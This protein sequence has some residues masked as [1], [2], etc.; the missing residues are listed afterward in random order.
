MCMFLFISSAGIYSQSQSAEQIK[1]K[2]AEIRRTTNWDNDSEAAKANA[3][4]KKLSKQLLVIAQKKETPQGAQTDEEIEK[5]AEHKQQMFDQIIKSAQAGEEADVLLADPIKEEIKEEFKEDES[6]KDF[7]EE[8][9]KE[10]TILVIDM[11]LKTIQRTISVMQNFKSIETL[12][13]TGGEKGATVNLNDLLTRAAAYPL[14]TLCIINFRNFVT[15]IP[16]QVNQFKNLKTLELFNNHLTK[17][18][19]ISGLASKLDS[20]FL[21][22]NPIS[23]VFPDINSLTSLKKLGIAKTNISKAEADKIKQ[24]FPNCE[25]LVK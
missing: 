24:K 7:K 22:I 19:N 20:L 3:E 21:D 23:T 17:L 5:D 11:S 4:I 16:A 13:I 9:L 1:K 10:A 18:P 14:K 12:I 2:M 8:Y 15:S 6:P 25:V